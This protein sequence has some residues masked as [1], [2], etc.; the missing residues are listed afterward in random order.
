MTT[1]RDR[2]KPECAQ[3]EFDNPTRPC[4]CGGLR[5]ATAEPSAKKRIYV[6]AKSSPE[7]LERAVRVMRALR[8]AGHEVT[9]DWTRDV[10][11]DR[12]APFD[13]AARKRAAWSDL[14]GVASADVVI[15]LWHPELRG[16]L[17]ELGAALAGGVADI[18]VLGAKDEGAPNI[19]YT[20]VRHEAEAPFLA[21]LGCAPAIESHPR[22]LDDGSTP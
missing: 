20:L 5:K 6:A 7:E 12:V 22:P 3:I 2:H 11:T 15:I 16:A 19:F 9:Y 17:V 14:M 8:A 4:T 21:S 13:L 18:V 10:L 1:W